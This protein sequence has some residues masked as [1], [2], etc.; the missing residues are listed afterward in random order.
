MF[1][2]KLALFQEHHVYY[3]ASFHPIGFFLI[4]KE[5]CKAVSIIK[6][7]IQASKGAAV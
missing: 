6:N 4:V 5:N 3:I 2:A 1:S 7:S